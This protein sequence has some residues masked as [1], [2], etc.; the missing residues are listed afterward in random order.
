MTARQTAT[1]DVDDLVLAALE[2]YGG[3]I[4]GRTKLQKVVYFLSVL[5]H[6]EAGYKPHYYGPYSSEVTAVADSQ[7]VRAL[8]SE[9]L[10]RFNSAGF[11]AHDREYYRYTYELT[12]K[13]RR[14][15]EWRRQR[16][17][18]GYADVEEDLRRI[19]DGDPDYRLLSYAAKL[20]MI[21]LQSGAPLTLAEA[22]D[23]AQEY[24]WEMTADETEEGAKLLHKL[25]LVR[26]T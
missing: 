14:V 2:A 5:T 19:V 21:L 12:A 8:M 15:L 4:E 10:E 3:T 11:P 22:L 17:P 26:R 16:E 23:R 13:G 25:S 9:R 7:V 6:V 1:L 20:H 18:D 24:G